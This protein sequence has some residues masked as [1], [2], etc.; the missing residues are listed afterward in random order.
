MITTDALGRSTGKPGRWLLLVALAFLLAACASEPKIDTEQDIADALAEEKASPPP[1]DLAAAMM[2]GQRENGV[3]PADMEP[4]F[5]VN[6]NNVE[7]RN[8][9][10]GLVKGT[11]YNMALHPDVSGRVSLSL[12]NVTVPEVMDTVRDLYGF[13]FR[14]NRSGYLVLPA[15]L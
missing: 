8:F 11:D 4:R 14:R 1:P 13:D 9:F 15:S 6:A 12:K 7:A 10:M 3:D 5:D 2:P